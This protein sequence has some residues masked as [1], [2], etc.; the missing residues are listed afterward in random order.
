MRYMNR[1]FLGL[2]KPLLIASL[3]VLL[4]ACGSS[5]EEGYQGR[6][7]V[8]LQAQANGITYRLSGAFFDVTGPETVTLS[9]DADPDAVAIQHTLT[10][11]DY[12]IQLRE[13]WQLER[14]SPVD[15]EFDAI[16][17]ELVSDDPLSFT[18][19]DEEQ[20]DV[21]YSFETDG[22]LVNLAEGDLNVG[23]D[24]TNT[25]APPNVAI[26]S[27]ADG[28][29][30]TPAL[31]CDPAS[32]GLQVPVQGTTSAVDGSTATVQVGVAGAVTVPI[33]A[34]AFSACAAASAGEDQTLSALVRDQTTGL[35]ATATISV[36]VD[37]PPALSIAAPA[38]QVVG[39]REGVVQL[40]WTATSDAG[41]GPLATYQL[42]C[43]T[44]DIV[45]E[46]GWSVASAVPV[47][48]VP[49]AAGATES[50]AFE[51]FRTG[52]VRFCVMRGADALGALTPFAAGTS[53]QVDNPFLSQRYS[54]LDDANVAGTVGSISVEPLGDING[55]GIEDFIYGAVNQG[56]QIF[57][58]DPDV[59]LDTSDTETADV[60]IS[61]GGAVGATLGFGAE[62]AGLGDIT[63]DGI[64]DFAVS[65]RG[66][67]TVFV[68]FGRSA[69]TPWPATL[70]LASVTPC[71]ADVCIVGAGLGGATGGLFGWDV[72]SANFDGV[73]PLDLVVSARTANTVGQVFVLLGGAQLATTGTTLTIPAS[74]PDGFIINPPASRTNFGFAVGAV[75]GTGSFDDVIIGANGVTAGA[76][77]AAAFITAGRSATPGSGL[78]AISPV[79]VDTGT[80][81]NFGNPVRAVGDFDGDGAQDFSLGLDFNEGGAVNVYRGS[82]SGFSNAAGSVLEFRNDLVPFVDDNYG[83]YIACGERPELG[84]VG[85]LDGDGT[86]DLLIGSTAPDTGAPA[87]STGTAQL[88]YG[89]AGAQASARGLADFSYAAASGQVVPNF[90]GDINADGFDDFVLL[91]S[92]T[93]PNVAFLR[94]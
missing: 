13:G 40:T 18:I 84:L 23:I 51:G 9:S 37:E 49:G 15:M 38:A 55:D 85:D 12:S 56:A 32:A 65:A 42:R 30:L 88:F 26:T 22:T 6:L 60:V 11:G 34:G 73:L 81:A 89:A 74:A 90:V 25:G 27:P 59:S 35:E 4:S 66:A 28:A 92:G 77:T 53:V 86:G 45:D 87:G 21:I 33:S 83:T 71:S 79:E 16:N 72:H 44:T 3:G 5:D 20:T 93:G 70:T 76:T 58:G 78:V 47:T 68:F 2:G 24:V 82:A 39:R 80:I 19:I 36:D 69:A 52:T 14:R 62:V 29:V 48:T 17:A 54:V 43:A 91:D 8:R 57:F 94:Y 1:F 46:A 31:D 63:G 75:Q 10:A 67:N 7:S 61:N 64:S 50:E 41:G